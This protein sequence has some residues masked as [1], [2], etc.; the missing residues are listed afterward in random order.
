[1]LI[2]DNL[3]GILNVAIPVVKIRINIFERNESNEKEF[4]GAGIPPFVSWCH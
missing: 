3:Y 4:E 2:S 1:M